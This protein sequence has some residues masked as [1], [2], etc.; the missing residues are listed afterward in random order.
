MD[1]VRRPEDKQ[2]A[3]FIPVLK[4]RTVVF[5]QVGRDLISKMM[6]VEFK[7]MNFALK[8]MKGRA[9]AGILYQK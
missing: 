8:M 4:I 6:N 5:S 3:V 7:M 9:C 1:H 2:T